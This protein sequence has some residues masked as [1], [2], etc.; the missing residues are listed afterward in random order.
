METL[1]AYLKTLDPSEQ[2]AYA[3]RCGT[4][5][6]YLRKALSTKPKLDGATVRRLW[7]HSH[8]KVSR[9]E[10]RGDIWTREADDIWPEAS[11]KQQAAA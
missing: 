3:T 1:R 8:G 6:G 10:L 5:I 4:S 7:D 11:A 9:H 2:D